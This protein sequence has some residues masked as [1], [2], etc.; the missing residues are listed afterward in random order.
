MN[1]EQAR[2]LHNSIVEMSVQPQLYSDEAFEEIFNLALSFKIFNETELNK[3]KD[4]RKKLVEMFNNP[5][6]YSV[7]TMFDL[8]GMSKSRG[9]KLPVFDEWDEFVTKITDHIKQNYTKITDIV[10]GN[11]WE[12]HAR[13]YTAYLTKKSDY[14][15]FGV[16]TGPCVGEKKCHNWHKPEYFGPF[17][18]RC[19]QTPNVSNVDCA[20]ID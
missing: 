19:L 18:D 8:E 12:V 5:K 15:V 1:K 11:S 3:V 9:E 6:Y 14:Y 7:D 4:L 2:K 17:I 10:K 20:F 13:N 16:Y